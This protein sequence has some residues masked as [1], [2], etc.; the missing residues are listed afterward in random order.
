[1]FHKVVEIDNSTKA[2]T[3]SH[4]VFEQNKRMTAELYDN[5]LADLQQTAAL[6]QAVVTRL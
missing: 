1:M 5:A 3:L 4:R 6:R 2:C